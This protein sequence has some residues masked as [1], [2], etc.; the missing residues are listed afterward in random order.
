MTNILWILEPSTEAPTDAANES[1][2]EDSQ[3]DSL[4]EQDTSSQ[5][6]Q[7][8]LQEEPM[9]QENENDLVRIVIHSYY[10]W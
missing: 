10:W 7:A 1:Y 8:E 9:L 2:G 3:D 6:P 4:L 5:E